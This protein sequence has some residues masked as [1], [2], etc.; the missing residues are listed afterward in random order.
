[1]YMCMAHHI[2]HDFMPIDLCDCEQS[3]SRGSGAGRAANL[4]APVTHCMKVNQVGAGSNGMTTL[5]S[6]PTCARTG[7]R[8]KCGCQAHR[9]GATLRRLFEPDVFP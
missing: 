8:A 6:L 9:K 4:L 1:M 5:T 3:A 7:K 2:S